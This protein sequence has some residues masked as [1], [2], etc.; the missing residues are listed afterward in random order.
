M[1]TD[2]K[3]M[4]PAFM[5][6]KD[7][8]HIAGPAKYR[9]NGHWMTTE[10]MRVKLEASKE[11]AEILISRL[12]ISKSGDPYT[13]DDLMSDIYSLLVAV[14]DGELAPEELKSAKTSKE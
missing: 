11:A 8:H 1:S 5:V 6:A 14:T 3:V 2:K 9:V 12:M 7:S 10:Q 4:P 13:G